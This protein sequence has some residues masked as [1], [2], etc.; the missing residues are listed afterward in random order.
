MLCW[1]QK[2]N[3][4]HKWIEQLEARDTDERLEQTETEWGGQEIK[5]DKE[6]LGER[7]RERHQAEE[8]SLFNSLIVYKLLLIASMF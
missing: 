5:T 7:E 8:H 2:N 6:K 4:I 3:K 1:T